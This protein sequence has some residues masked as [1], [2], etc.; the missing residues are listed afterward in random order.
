[1]GTGYIERFYG[2]ALKETEENRSMG[3]IFKAYDIRGSYPDEL[4][5]AMAKKIG[6]AFTHLLN[7][8]RIVVG[9]DMRI[10]ASA[11]TKAFIE[12]VTSA[13]ASITDIGMV[14]TPLL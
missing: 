8:Q 2:K 11:L 13:G 1:M 6:V 3:G 7:A 12:G 4:D 14:T 9:R 5:E 10:S